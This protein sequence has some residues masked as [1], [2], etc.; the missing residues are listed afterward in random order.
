MWFL[1]LYLVGI[2]TGVIVMAG[3][4]REDIQSD[5][6]YVVPVV[7]MGLLWPLTFLVLVGMY[8]GATLNERNQVKKMKYKQLAIEQAKVDQE[9]KRLLQAEGIHYP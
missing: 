8:A 6:G 4:W 3:R 2:A 1:W 9:Y 5:G 7:G